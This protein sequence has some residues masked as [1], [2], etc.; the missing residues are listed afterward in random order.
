MSRALGAAHREAN[1]GMRPDD[2]EGGS[3]TNKKGEERKRTEI[4]RVVS[5]QV[6]P[7]GTTLVDGVRQLPEDAARVPDRVQIQTAQ[8]DG[9]AVVNN[10]DG[11]AFDRDASREDVKSQLRGLI[12]G[13]FAWFDGLEEEAD[14][15]DVWYLATAVKQKLVLVPDSSCPDGAT[16]DF[17][18][19]NTTN[20]FWNCRIFIV[21]RDPIPIELLREWAGPKSM[22]YRAV[23]ESD[24]DASV[25]DS[26]KIPVKNNKRLFSFSS[27]EQDEKPAKKKKKGSSKRKWSRGS[28]EIGDKSQDP[29]IDL[30]ADDTR[31]STNTPDF[32][33]AI[34]KPL[35]M[36]EDPPSPGRSELHHDPKLGNPYDRNITFEF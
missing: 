15:T 21:P 33:R 22:S 2:S 1:R 32:L 14:D 4:F 19:G 24:P 26:E 20:G 12:P 35:P 7:W 36:R 18:K 16:L 17:N 27:D 8:Q 34:P 25:S 10:K 29:I 13:P 6:I 30:T 31:T 11:I 5:V 3:K 23:D 28:A 9:L